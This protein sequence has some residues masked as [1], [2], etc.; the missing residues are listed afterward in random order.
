[1]DISPG[2]KATVER[3]VSNLVSELAPRQ[4]RFFAANGKYWEGKLTHDTIPADGIGRA[5]IK[6]KKQTDFDAWDTFDGGVTLPASMECCVCVSAYDGPLG[7]GYC[8][9][10][11]V[12]EAG[13]KYRRCENIG[14]DTRRTFDW[15]EYN[16]TA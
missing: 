12:E 15:V 7:K 2:L 16:G 10:G 8:V 13:R 1:M 9:F 4:A 11:F 14:P 6:T 3:V 5:P